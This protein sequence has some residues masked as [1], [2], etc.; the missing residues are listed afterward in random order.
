MKKT[1]SVLTLGAMIAGSSVFASTSLNTQLGNLELKLDRVKTIS[2]LNKKTKEQQ[3]EI[4]YLS[5]ELKDAQ[6]TLSRT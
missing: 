3:N 5:K 6:Y 1:I 2:V 4:E